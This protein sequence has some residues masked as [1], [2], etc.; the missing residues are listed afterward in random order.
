MEY[1]VGDAVVFST[2]G[3]MIVREVETKVR[4]SRKTEMSR[5]TELKTFITLTLRSPFDPHRTTKVLSDHD[6]LAPLSWVLQPGGVP[7]VLAE[8]A[9]P[10][11]D[12]EFRTWGDSGLSTYSTM[13][14]EI[15]VDDERDGTPA[16][17]NACQVAQV[18]RNLTVR[19]YRHELGVR[20]SELLDTARTVLTSEAAL[21]AGIDRAQA[22]AAI[23]EALAVHRPAA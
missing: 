11:P 15:S 14:G 2:Y 23:E 6:C 8:L 1:S 3:A 4:E 17:L 10:V 9:G 20:E 22:E 19:Q 16:L 13:I 21:G 18:V 12:P 5:E 7:G